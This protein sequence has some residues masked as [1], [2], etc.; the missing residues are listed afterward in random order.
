MFKQIRKQKGLEILEYGL[1][2][3]L[4]IGGGTALYVTLGTS[5]NTNVTQTTACIQTP[6]AENCKTPGT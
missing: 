5:N 2:A 3:A 1:I 4:I 6:N